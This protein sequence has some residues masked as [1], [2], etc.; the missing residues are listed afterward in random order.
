MHS[1]W[2]KAD[3]KQNMKY[4][5]F[6]W[7]R[8]KCKF[9]HE[10]REI[11]VGSVF[12]GKS[13]TVTVIGSEVL[14]VIKE[15]NPKKGYGLNGFYFKFVI[16]TYKRRRCSFLKSRRFFSLFLSRLEKNI[17]RAI[18]ESK[19][20]RSAWTIRMIGS[21]PNLIRKKMLVNPCTLASSLCPT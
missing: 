8:E 7:W 5:L 1:I 13:L 15:V 18:W 10:Y 2:I 14:P 21:N 20:F 9:F 4:I 16:N 17:L 11:F 12:S 6:L 3:D 19:W